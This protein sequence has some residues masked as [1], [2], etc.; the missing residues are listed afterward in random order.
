MIGYG[1]NCPLK[2]LDISK[3]GI[4][5]KGLDKLLEGLRSNSKITHLNLEGND[6]SLG[7]S[8]KWASFMTDN[9]TLSFLNMSKCEL[10]SDAFKTI[11]GLASNKALKHLNISGNYL[12]DCSISHIS[13]SL[14]A[15]SS[16]KILDVS[17]NDIKNKGAVELSNAL[18][19][20]KSLEI[21]VIKCN[22]L[23]DE[24]GRSL[25]EAVRRTPN[26]KKVNLKENPINAKYLSEVKKSTSVN[27]A[28]S[29]VKVVPKLKSNN[30]KLVVNESIFDLVNNRTE[31]KINEK[32]R[33]ESECK[34]KLLRLEERKK[35]EHDL[36]ANLSIEL[37]NKRF[38]HQQ[39]AGSLKKLEE[40]LA[41]QRAKQERNV[42]QYELRIAQ[43][44][45]AISKM[46]KESKF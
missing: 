11:E 4:N 6:F 9:H 37:K 42:H 22:R 46:E 15:N 38:N 16:L 26:H 41:V 5:T 29:M 44:D 1:Q 19:I 8:D 10:K 40:S 28:R 21:L 23:K 45:Q 7:L 33:L 13:K 31:N 12:D 3:N 39:L 14:V 18:K 32:K 30:K 43:I 17:C 2:R 20:N 35:T 25:N 27:Q 36:F 34:K 24:A